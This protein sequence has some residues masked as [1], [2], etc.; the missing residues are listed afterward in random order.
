MI[1]CGALHLLQLVLCIY[2]VILT[3]A[4]ATHHSVV[5]IEKEILYGTEGANALKHIY[6]R[7]GIPLMM[8][9]CVWT[10]SVMR[11]PQCRRDK[12]FCRFDQQNMVHTMGNTPS[13]TDHT[14]QPVLAVVV[15]SVSEGP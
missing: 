4:M 9:K 12:T 14:L 8:S 2:L 5:H 15:S 10:C 6:N 11:E 13:E 7:P 1:V 3:D